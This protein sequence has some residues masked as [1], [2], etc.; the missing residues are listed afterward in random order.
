MQ[1]V[2]ITILIDRAQP[3]GD[4]QTTV[5]HERIHSLTARTARF[6]QPARHRHAT[7]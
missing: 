1:I 3:A 2:S 7:A 5:V 6:M 4:V